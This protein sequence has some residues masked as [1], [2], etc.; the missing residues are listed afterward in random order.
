MQASNTCWPGWDSLPGKRWLSPALIA[1]HISFYASLF[2]LL[3]HT[4]SFYSALHGFFCLRHLFHMHHGWIV[5]MSPHSSSSGSCFL[6][7]FIWSHSI[8]VLFRT[9]W[10]PLALCG[11]L[12]QGDC[13]SLMLGYSHRL[14]AEALYCVSLNV[15]IVT[16]YSTHLLYCTSLWGTF[17]HPSSLCPLFLRLKTSDGKVGMSGVEADAWEQNCHYG[18]DWQGS[19]FTQT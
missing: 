3:C 16:I 6:S 1:L 18:S 19:R 2:N 8:A 13:T 10:L 12:L 17:T 4:P 11:W 5:H 9:W 7:C 14:L 15:L